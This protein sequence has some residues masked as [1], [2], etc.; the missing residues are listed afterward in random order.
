MLYIVY[1]KG[2]IIHLKKGD[3]NPCSIEKIINV[4]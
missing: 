3:L 1:F 2:I 4:T